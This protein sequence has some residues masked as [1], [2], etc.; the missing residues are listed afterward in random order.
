MTPKEQY[1]I[2]CE[3]ETTIPLFLQYWWMEAVCNGKQWDVLL[4]TRNGEIVAAM[5]YLCG[6]KLRMKYIIQPQQTQIN[7]IW[8]KPE[9]AD[10]ATELANDFISQLK[11]LQLAYY[12]QQYPIASPFP[13]CFKENG[14]KVKERVTYRV[15]NL[16]DID[17]VVASF[18]K[19][20]KRQLQKA[21]TLRMDLDM[22]GDEFYNFHTACLAERKKTISYSREFFMVLYKAAKAHLQGQII[23][24]RNMDGQALAAVFLVWDAN[25]AYFLIPC[26]SPAYKNSGASALLVLEAMKFARGKSTSFDFEGSMVSGIANSYRQFGTKKIIY[27]SVEKY[28]KP[29]F[30]LFLFANWLRTWKKR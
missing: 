7:G 24:I 16:V 29:I 23:A 10:E 30:R 20:K 13:S 28:Y 6:K 3:Q 17:V 5:P 9:Y 22:S 12:Y 19:N 27:Y 15:D 2:L 25:S 18:S 21:L 26:Y 14:F 11:E 1:R 8:V 4:C